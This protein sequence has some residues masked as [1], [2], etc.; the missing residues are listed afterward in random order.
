MKPENLV[1]NIKSKYIQTLNEELT[2]PI[3]KL[4]YENIEK[5]NNW[6]YVIGGVVYFINLEGTDFYK[7]GISSTKKSFLTRL[8]V[9]KTA[10]PFDIKIITA[11]YLEKGI[12]EP[13]IHIEKFLHNYFKKQRKIR[14]WFTFNKNE[15]FAIYEFLAFELDI[16]DY[17]I[18]YEL[19]EMITENEKTGN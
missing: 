17:E 7:I 12:S 4:D 8:N 15:V 14:E 1:W 9:F 6:N 10:M 11:I 16:W 2:I 18:N 3:T 5:T 13:A 19:E